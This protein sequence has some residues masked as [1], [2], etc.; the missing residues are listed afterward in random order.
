MEEFGSTAARSKLCGLLSLTQR[1]QVGIALDPV[2]V[3]KGVLEAIDDKCELAEVLRLLAADRIRLKRHFVN[4]LVD[5]PTGHRHL[6]SARVDGDKARIRGGL[7]VA[8]VQRCAVNLDVVELDAE[9]ELVENRMPH[10]VAGVLALVVIAE[11]QLTIK[12]LHLLVHFRGKEEGKQVVLKELLLN[13]VVEHGRDALL[14]ELGVGE[15]NDSVEILSEYS[16]LA[17]DIPELLAFNY[18]LA[19]RLA[20]VA[21]ADA[22]IVEVKVA[23]ETAT[24]EADVGALAC[25]L[26]GAAQVVIVREMHVLRMHFLVQNPS[27]A[28]TSVKQRSYFLRWLVS[29]INVRNIAIIDMVVQVQGKAAR[30]FIFLIVQL[31]LVHRTVG[32]LLHLLHERQCV[33]TLL[34]PLLSH[35]DIVTHVF[36][37]EIIVEVFLAPL[38]HYSY[39]LRRLLLHLSL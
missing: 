37:E 30:T 5:G 9:H 23:G 21:A 14:R 11:G 15:A 27:V 28:T 1:V 13:H 31:T 17:L 25:L 16:I 3:R 20:N 24:P 6:G 8:N 39:S 7:V 38:E 34:I 12:A 4:D 29:H 2:V 18:Q 35:F 19:G 32:L 10:H 36:W 26:N 22:E 33:I